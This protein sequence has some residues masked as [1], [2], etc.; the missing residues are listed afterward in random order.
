M[1]LVRRASAIL[2]RVSLAALTLLAMV[3]F[4]VWVWADLSAPQLTGDVTL[5]GL[6]APV[7]VIR[8]PQGIPH[9]FAASATDAHVA[10]GFL[11]AQDRFA[12]MDAMRL[13]VRGRLA[14]L[15]G[16]TALGS[17]RFMRGLELA[18]RAEHI[19]AALAPE[20]RA[21]L[22]AYAAGVNAFLGAPAHAL[23]IEL[24]AA[25]RRPEPWHPVDSL[26]W[27]QLMAL[28]LGGNWRDELARARFADA[29]DPAVIRLLWPDWPVDTATSLRSR[30]EAWPA[31]ALDR[32]RAAL[33]EGPVVPLASNA[34]AFAGDRTANGAPLLANDPHLQFGAPG[35]WYLLRLSAPDFKRVGASAPGV[36]GLVLGHNGHVAWGMTTTGADSFDLFVER[37]HPENPDRVLTPQGNETFDRR[38]HD[39]RIR[40]EPDPIRFSVRWTRHGVVLADIVA[41]GGEA[42]PPGHVLVLATTLF[43][44]LNTSADALIRMN[45][46]RDVPGMLAAAQTW[47]APVQN[48]FVADTGGAI[49]LAVIGALPRRK[50][51]DGA[52]PAPG[53]SGDHDWDGL[54]DSQSLPR[55]IS[56]SSGFL[57]NA[58][59]R[60]I[61]DGASPHITVDWD[62]PYRALRLQEMLG[63][64]QGQDIATTRLRQQD[65]VSLH[66]RAVMAAALDYLDPPAALA[67]PWRMLRG[68]TGEMRRDLP[69]PLLYHAWMRVLRERALIALLGDAALSAPPV[70]REAPELLLAI[71]AGAT[72]P[73]NTLDCRALLLES[74]DAAF[75][76]LVAAYGPDPARWRWGDAHVAAFENPV[77]RA[78]PVIGRALRIAVATDGD[79]FT[80]NRGTSRG[81]DPARFPHVHGAGLRAIYDLADLDRARFA[82]APGQSGHPL[83]PHWS[84]LAAPWSAGKDLEIAGTRETLRKTGRVLRLLPAP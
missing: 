31:P 28:H 80:V 56:P 7:E 73:C 10:Q 58:N 40:G 75:R 38:S 9:V 30:P 70:A 1:R 42:A 45:A 34:W 24:R 17:D 32:L 26:L 4:G 67:V 19:Y 68:W 11:H 13:M 71:A 54:I 82:I 25:G 79:N 29:L 83:S 84:D 77:W 47:I 55:Q 23:P 3:V 52:W 64:A 57:M 5:P 51:G 16:R 15:V 63:A 43:T 14:E 22:D 27:G 76:A 20:S 46:A 35:L 39:F 8:D 61:A 21:V 74:L 48:L 18:A 72:P 60:L 33:P 65:H 53:W 2:A 69:E 36:P 41:E 37:L 81:S 44:G 62:A 66:A 49:A 12:Q 78:I 6:A 59:N 50:G